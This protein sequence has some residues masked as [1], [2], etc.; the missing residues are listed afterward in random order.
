MWKDEPLDADN[1]EDADVRKRNAL[2]DDPNPERRAADWIEE[3]GPEG[4]SRDEV[5]EELEASGFDVL[6]D[7]DFDT[8]AKFPSDMPNW[9]DSEDL[10]QLTDLEA[11]LEAENE[12]LSNERPV[13]D[14]AIRE[15]EADGDEPVE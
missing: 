15:L 6:E 2:E 1:D 3:I 5:M 13:E 9:S 14:Q 12:N 4:M 8:S 10:E 7:D 11:R